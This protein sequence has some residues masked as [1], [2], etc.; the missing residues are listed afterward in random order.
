[1]LCNIQSLV[2]ASKICQSNNTE[3]QTLLVKPWV[4]VGNYGDA[5]LAHLKHS[6]CYALSAHSHGSY[7][8]IFCAIRILA[9]STSVCKPK[10]HVSVKGGQSKSSW[11]RAPF[12]FHL[13]C[14]Y[15]RFQQKRYC[16]LC[17]SWFCVVIKLLFWLMMNC[18]LF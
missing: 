15:R 4:V 6:F 12:A 7:I 16:E 17:F 2:C 9:I 14:L 8:S 18:L 13:D 3:K 5:A 11:L 10:N 1:M